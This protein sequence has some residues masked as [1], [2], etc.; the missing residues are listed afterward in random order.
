MGRL[1]VAAVIQWSSVYGS[2]EFRQMILVAVSV[3]DQSGF[4]VS[5][6]SASAFRVRVQ[7]DERSSFLASLDNFVEHGS[8]YEGSGKYSFAISPG[9]QGELFERDELIIYIT[10]RGSGGQGQTVAI[11]R[12]T[13]EGGPED[14]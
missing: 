4:G 5:G 8:G 1:I 10:V 3:T 6:L 9:P 12:H 2:T 13:V 11:A 7:V 14:L